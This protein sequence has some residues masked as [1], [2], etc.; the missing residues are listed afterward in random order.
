MRLLLVTNLF[1]TPSEP[2]RGI[3]ILQLVKRLMNHCDVTVVCPLPWFPT[4]KILRGLI[5]YA[6]YSNIPARYEIYG[7]EVYSPKYPLI[8]KIS[9]SYHAILMARG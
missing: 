1:P 3:F 9:E 8:S 7:I 6:Q 2:E 4:W 5:K